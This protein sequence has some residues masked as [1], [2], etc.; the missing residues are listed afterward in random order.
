MTIDRGPNEDWN[1]GRSNIAIIVAS[2]LATSN[3]DARRKIGQNGF[4]ING[5]LVTDPNAIVPWT[6][7]ESETGAFRVQFGQKKTVLVKPV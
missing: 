1:Y 2:G 3:G 5:K 4:R 7:V 6:D